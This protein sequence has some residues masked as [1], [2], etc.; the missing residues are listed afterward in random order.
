MLGK[1]HNWSLPLAICKLLSTQSNW[2]LHFYDALCVGRWCTCLPHTSSWGHPAGTP[3]PD[4]QRKQSQGV[5]GAMTSVYSKEG[6]AWGSYGWGVAKVPL[7]GP[8][9]RDS[10]RVLPPT[11]ARGNIPWGWKHGATYSP[12][13]HLLPLTWTCPFD[14]AALTLY[15]SFFFWW[16]EAVGSFI[17]LRMGRTW[18][19][20]GVDDLH[21]Q[22]QANSDSLSKNPRF[23]EKHLHKTPQVRTN[24]PQTWYFNPIMCHA[25]LLVH[26]VKLF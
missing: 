3:T 11:L 24:S 14:H 18:R 17:P 5:T 1:V 2:S 23:S 13:K 12:Q 20:D 26:H 22:R 9:V 16:E 6:Q 15:F 8:E 25:H 7:Y 21:P 4:S 19:W 10:S